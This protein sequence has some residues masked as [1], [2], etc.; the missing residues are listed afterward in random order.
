MRRLVTARHAALRLA[1]G[2]QWLDGFPKDAEVVLVA[3]TLEAGDEVVRAAARRSGAR[4]GLQRLTLGRLAGTLAEPVLAATSRV[5][6]SG[7]LLE[8]VVA[9]VVHRL[10]AAGSLVHF[11][12]V[13]SFPGFPRAVARTLEELRLGGVVAE[14]L[15]PLGDGGPELCAMALALE[16]ELAA[17]RLA[18]RATVYAE[19]AAVLRSGAA[20]PLAG[21]PLLL[22]D[23]SATTRCEAELL[24]ALCARAPV[25]LATVPSGDDLSLRA[26]AV[27]LAVEPIQLDAERAGGVTATSLARLRGHLFSA[28]APE[29]APLDETVRVSAHAGEARECVEIARAIAAEAGRGVPFDAMAVLLRTPGDYVSPLEEALRRAGIPAYFARGAT[30]PHP[31]GRALLALLACKAE[32]L[33]A[34]R[35]A[36][37]LSLSQVPDVYPPPPLEA[38]LLAPVEAELLGRTADALAGLHEAAREEARRA[39][40]PDP[41]APSAVEAGVVAGALRA[42]W[43]WEQFLVDAAVVGGRDRWARRL[44]GLAAELAA[45]AEAARHQHEDDA[46]ADAIL[47]TVK[48]LG[49]LRAFA[50]PLVERLGALPQAATWGEWLVALRALAEHALREAEPVLVTLAELEPLSPV[51][52]VT[53]DEVQDILTPRLLELPVAREKRAYGRVFVAPLEAARG[54]SFEVVFV[55]GLAERMFPS[56]TKL[57]EDPLLLDP[58]REQ[59]DAGLATQAVRAS[60][61]RLLLRLGVGA[62]AARL[63]LSYPRLDV[64]QSRP[65]V[66]S[67]YA[68]EALRAA[69]GDLRRLGELARQAGTAERLG[70]PAPAEP[71]DA[72]DDAE[73]DLALLGPRV[74]AEPGSV[75]GAARYLL[76]ANV[77]LARALR[78][79]ARRHLPAWTSADGLLQ[80]DALAM[81]AL[82][83]HAFTARSYSATALQHYAACP[84]RFFLQAL[85]RLSPWEEPV[86]LEALDPLTRGSLFH[87]VQFEVLTRLRAEAQLPV[88]PGNLD[89]A[90]AAVD[91]ALGVVAERYRDEL[92]PAI[93]RVWD[94]ALGGL[95]TELREWLRREADRA[96]GYVPERFELSF[97]LAERGREHADPASVA[98]AVA[99]PGGLSLRGAI[100]LV[101]RHPDGHLRVTD[102]KTGRVRVKEGVVVGGGEHLQPVLYALACE[103]L[104]GAP[105]HEG[106]LYYCTSD[107]TFAER[108]VAIDAAARAAAGTVIGIVGRALE[109]GF[110]PAA[111]NKGACRYCDFQV[112]C[113]AHEEARTAR[114]RYEPLDE[115]LTLRRLT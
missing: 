105:V 53:L 75:L 71:A 77:H 16:E 67:F 32:N 28:T 52:P 37:Y 62:A 11:G 22:L 29:V 107:G 101:E 97:G 24:Q 93:P 60:A 70:W 10:H 26:L 106:R 17:A 25:V 69:E 104:L 87:D 109:Q 102:H 56:R 115:L 39:E 33:S 3:P 34:R 43:R 42:P 12:P 72:I 86:A 103:A 54:L 83:K 114:K 2:A 89:R 73:Y 30:R 9:R 91:E 47:R 48:D 81:Q 23:V 95:R 18:D 4:F 110:F 100:D 31:G 49:H 40:Q 68:V 82:A 108:R 85:L 20:S 65:R 58:L 7:L 19:A 55:P 46:R 74:G 14:S 15:T 112:V 63:Y 99:L 21:H 8:A 92:A 90:L 50:L 61:E 5:P 96:D 88:R 27:A 36:E 76:Q 79:R 51:G 64:A 6:A 44:D 59:L 35:F 41:D 80:P 13:A 98:D 57:L 113:G 38:A 111:P 66:P 78:A 94:D 84:Y 45:R 1:A